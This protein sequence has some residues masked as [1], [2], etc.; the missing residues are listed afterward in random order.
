MQFLYS[1][2][3]QA[4]DG[5]YVHI[6]ELTAALASR[7][8]GVAIAG[9][10]GAGES[11][12]RKLDTDGGGG[13]RSRL[14]GPVYEAAEF[15]YSLQ[16]Y[17]RLGALCK[18]VR[19]DVLYER[20]NLFY[21]AGVW[22]RRRAGLPLILE[23]NAPLVDERSRH[24]RLASKLLAR[25]S[26]RRIW[27]AADAVLPVTGVLADHVK[28]AG[29][30]AEKIHVIQNGVSDAFLRAVDPAPVRQRYGLD[31][32]IVLGFTGFVR[33]WHGV[34]RV[35]RYIAER[36]REDLH[37]LMVGDGPARAGIE[38]LARE[39]G[40]ESQLS[41]V[42]IVQ[43]DEIP[44]YV[45][46]FDIALQP[47]VVDYASPLKLF[48]YMA[49]SRAI[50]APGSANICEVLSDGDDAVLFEQGETGGFEKALDQL[51][52]SEDL[53]ARLGHAARASLERQRLTWDA[54]AARVEAIAENLL[55]VVK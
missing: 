4:A 53:R 19:P 3:T 49:L 30:P 38:A 41:S 14:P 24:G 10:E 40:V 33:E 13:L 23:V 26:E 8:H 55:N 42:G 44:G 21:H 48:E 22:L 54:N 37:L 31:G 17:R 9:P 43:R 45:A 7:G 32:K 28:A 27:T 25:E 5:Q 36:G 6:Q 16:G 46:A 12:A 51:I 18:K 15:L 47:A 2:R 52:E 11:A 34:D 35:V 39:L 20:Y 50:I 1:H 29:V